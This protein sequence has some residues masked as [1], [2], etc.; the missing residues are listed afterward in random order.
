[1]EDKIILK[2]KRKTFKINPSS[3]AI[4]LPKPVADALKINVGDKVD[5]AVTSSG[6]I[7][8]QKGEETNG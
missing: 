8:I 4:I 2:F 5:L 3:I 7:V 1:M 6:Q